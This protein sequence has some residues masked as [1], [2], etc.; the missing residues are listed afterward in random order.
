MCKD[1]VALWVE[2]WVKVDIE[3]RGEKQ[4]VGAE[5]NTSVHH[6]CKES[7]LTHAIHVKDRY[8]NGTLID[9]LTKYY[10]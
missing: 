8:V 10:Q 1:I 7:G 4:I 2:V 3:V 5:I 6:R 9:K